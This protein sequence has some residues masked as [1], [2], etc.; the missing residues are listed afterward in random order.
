MEGHVLEPPPDMMDLHGEE[1]WFPP[2]YDEF[3]STLPENRNT[4]G[5]HYATCDWLTPEL[6][7]E[8]N[9]CLPKVDD[10]DP[11]N[12][13]ARNQE[14]FETHCQQL[15]PIGRKFAS[16]VQLD[17]FASRFLDKWAI[18]K[19]KAGKSIRCFYSKTPNTTAYKPVQE[20]T[21]RRNRIPT[22]K[23]Q[24]QCP[25]RI[26]YTFVSARFPNRK[27]EFPTIYYPVRISSTNFT[28]TCN[29]NTS[30]L[31]HA[32]K[33]SG[34]IVPDMVGLKH[35]VDTLWRNPAMDNGS[36]RKEL[37]DHLP[38]YTNIGASFL[39]NFR[40]RAYL[41]KIKFPNHEL[42][43]DVAQT[44]ASKKEMSPD[45]ELL[46]LDNPLVARN[47]Q[48]M[49]RR[50][51]VAGEGRN[52]IWHIIRF[53]SDTKRKSPGFD[54]RINYVDD[55]DSPTHGQPIGIC[56]MFKEMKQDVGRFGDSLFLDAQKRQ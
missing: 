45:E 22:A 49:Y 33:K 1:I 8:I 13:N 11:Q 23:L 6:H 32:K 51:M 37:E 28:H 20:E 26:S 55:E 41:W 21:K 53:L 36:L 38:Q 27:I 17:Q 19:V 56:W 46:P 47:L 4:D 3:Q 7:G 40:K 34:C 44:L 25:F 43:A 39:W 16:H 9:S 35:L 54:F 15:F 30:E 42:T 48:E 29:M 52:S 31:R 5:K 14:A 18:L 24:C 2:F 12:K 50:A 10:I